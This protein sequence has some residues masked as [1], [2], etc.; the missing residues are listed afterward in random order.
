MN[1]FFDDRHSGPTNRIIQVARRLLEHGIETVLCL[2]EG[3]GNAAEM[4]RGA[5]VPVRRVA[6][7]RVP[8]PSDPRRVLTWAARLPGD[9]LRF[10]RLLRR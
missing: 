6:F 4:A 2:P 3:D 10:A 5:G 9:V 7:E 8:R 1:V